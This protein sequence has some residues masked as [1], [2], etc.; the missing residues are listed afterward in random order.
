MNAKECIKRLDEIIQI[1]EELRGKNKIELVIDTEDVE[2]LR[3]ARDVYVQEVGWKYAN[4][5]DLR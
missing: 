4:E 3:C 1:F 2:A 5:D